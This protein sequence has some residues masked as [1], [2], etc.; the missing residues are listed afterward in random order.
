MYF[1]Y[2]NIGSCSIV[3]GFLLPPCRPVMVLL[4]ATPPRPT[5]LL[6]HVLLL[7]LLAAGS[8]PRPT[9][10]LAT[11]GTR[12]KVFLLV[13]LAAAGPPHP[14]P[15]L[16]TAGCRAKAHRLATAGGVHRMLAAAGKDGTPSCSAF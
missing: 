4:A 11:A 10:Q 6:A 13:P 16:A 1:L 9:L 12:A 14:R 3:G 7:L 2:S 8:P 5:R 15:R